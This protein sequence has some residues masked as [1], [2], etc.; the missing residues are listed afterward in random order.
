MSMRLLAATDPDHGKLTK[1]L[2]ARVLYGV[3]ISTREYGPLLHV[4]GEILQ[5][6]RED[7]NDGRVHFATVFAREVVYQ[8]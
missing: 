6:T 7:R 4:R 5:L 1:M 2:C 3:T 8:H